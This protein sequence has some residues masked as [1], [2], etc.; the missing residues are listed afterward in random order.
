MCMLQP[1]GADYYQY[2]AGRTPPHPGYCSFSA[3]AWHFVVFNTTCTVVPGGARG[4]CRVAG[5]YGIVK[6]VPNY[7]SLGRW[8][9][10]FKAT[11]GRTLDRVAMRC[12]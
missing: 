12:H 7:L 5:R 4:R 11:D 8:V 1:A 10:A 6:I 2:V 3:E 9:Q